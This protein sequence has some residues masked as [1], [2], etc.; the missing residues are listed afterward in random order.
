MEGVNLV[1]GPGYA[2]L[3]P[4]HGCYLRHIL[5]GNPY[6][7]HYGRRSSASALHGRRGRLTVP[8]P[9]L[10]LLLEKPVDQPRLPVGV[11]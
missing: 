11:F 3:D 1:W 7:Q 9:V 10:Q 4:H 2:R 6:I 8:A 5:R